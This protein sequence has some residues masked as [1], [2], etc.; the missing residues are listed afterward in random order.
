MDWTAI[1]LS[2]ARSPA[3]DDAP[4]A[5]C[6]P[7]ARLLAGHDALAGEVP[8]GGRRR[9]AAGAAADGARLLRAA[10]AR[11]RAARWA[12]LSSRSPGGPLP[13]CFGGLLVASVLYSLPFAVQPFTAALRGR[14]PP[15]HRGLLVPGRLAPRDLPARRRCPWP[16][17]RHPLRHG[18]DLRAHAGRVRRGAHGR[19]QHPRRTR[20]VSISIYDDVQALDYAAA[21][22]DRA[23]AAR[24]LLRRAG[25]DL[26]RS[27]GR[28]WAPWPTT[29][30]VRPSRSASAAGPPIQ[31]RPWSC[32]PDG[33]SVTVLFGPSGA[34]KTTSCAASPGSSGP[35]AGAIRFGGETWFD[36]EARHRPSA[37]AAA[38]RAPLPGLRPLPAPDRRAERRATASARCPPPS[39]GE[40]VARDCSRCCGSTGWRIAARASSPAAS[41]SGWRLAGRSP[42]A[43]ACC[44]STS[45]CP[46]W[47]RRRARASAASCAG[48]WPRC[49]LPTLLV[50]HDRT[51]GAGA[52]RP[53]GGD[54][55][56][57]GAP[58][59]PGRRR[60][61]PPGGPR[62]GAAVGVETVLAARVVDR[63]A[64][65]LVTVEVG[66]GRS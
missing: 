51:R 18:P 12:G 13:F 57:P 62:R 65:G 25:R 16:G 4:P 28:A 24:L 3:C 21:G 35:S 36:A 60:V 19:R 32:P 58:G 27:S 34:G 5:A 10:R 42:R 52:R 33:A 43:R 40:R 26:R 7:A 9:A 63:P 17:R 44:S 41:S 29:L 47:T 53:H 14:G 1:A 49:G 22:R 31:C 59:R 37:P 61:Q 56:R 20:T 15:P 38:R 54:R 8:R 46:R 11:A 39:G 64:E 30:V 55:G 66:R 50:T 45:P 6:R 2:A 23:A 48:C